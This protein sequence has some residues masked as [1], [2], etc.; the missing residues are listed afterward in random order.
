MNKEEYAVQ[1]GALAWDEDTHQ[2]T[3]MLAPGF[4]EEP[5]TIQL[6]MLAGWRDAVESLYIEY[7]D[8]YQKK[9]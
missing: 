7:L 4:L 2:G 6:A 8:T 1:V 3:V 5:P 9:H